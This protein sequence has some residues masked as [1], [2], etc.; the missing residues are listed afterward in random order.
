MTVE[1]IDVMDVSTT[2]ALSSLSWRSCAAAALAAG[3]GGMRSLRRCGRPVAAVGHR[4]GVQ[5]DDVAAV[6]HHDPE[7]VGGQPVPGDHDPG[8]GGDVAELAADRV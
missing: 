2:T 3:P 6:A 1:S 5:G 7:A 4:G 8:G